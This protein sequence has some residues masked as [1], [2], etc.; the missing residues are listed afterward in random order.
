MLAPRVNQKVIQ[1]SMNRSFITGI[2]GPRRVGKSTLVKS[3]LQD[4]APY[5]QLNL[6]LIKEQQAIHNLSLRVVIEEKVHQKI[7]QSKIWVLI[8]E[9]QKYPEIFDEVKAL[10]DEFKDQDLLKFIIT[11]SSQL[12]IHQLSAESLAGRIELFQLQEFSL[13]ETVNLVDASL[14]YQSVLDLILAQKFDLIEPRV[15][16]L[17][18]YRQE[19][20]SAL[21]LQLIWGGLP[22]VLQQ[23]SDSDKIRYLANYL[24]TYL[25]KDVRSMGRIDIPVYQKLLEVVAEQT[26]S[27]RDDKRLIDSIGIARDTLKK[28]RNYLSATLVYTEVYPFIHQSLRRMVK[29]PKAYLLNN[30]LISY[31]TGLDQLALLEKSGQI[32]HRFENWFLKELQITK[33]RHARKIDIYYW[34]TH[35]GTEVDFVLSA[36]PNIYPFEVTYTQ[37]IDSKKVKNLC[38]FMKEEGA[39]YGFYIYQGEFRYDA[40][41][42]IYFLPSFAI[43]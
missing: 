7:G 17:R 36:K 38:H 11:G 6:D 16:Q 31:L 39:E 42:K 25:E 27:L 28:Y 13:Q 8:D 40:V 23:D 9:A 1:E 15:N 21:K 2:L 29:S 26:G 4:K 3:L 19:L 20:S 32:G 10:Y 30:G 12:D 34:R 41:N 43:G 33:S 24:Q 35:T 5:C 22:E 18:L 14:P 37:K